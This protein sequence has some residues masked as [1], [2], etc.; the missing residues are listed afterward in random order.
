[1]CIRDRYQKREKDVLVRLSGQLLRGVHLRD[2]PTRSVSEAPLC[3]GVKTILLLHHA[4]MGLWG[5]EST[6][7]VI[8]TGGPENQTT[9]A[10]GRRG[11][12]PPARSPPTPPP[13]ALAPPP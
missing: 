6:L 3:F 12:P 11:R 4:R 5:V 8:R 1:M 9:A 2:Q 7:A 10:A 13:P